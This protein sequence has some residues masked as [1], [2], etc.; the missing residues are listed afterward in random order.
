MIAAPPT[1]ESP[2]ETERMRVTGQAERVLT[3]DWYDDLVTELA[4]FLS[5]EVL[6][7]MSHPDIT[8]N[9]LKSYATQ[10]NVLY[11]EAPTVSA[12]G[13]DLTPILRPELWPLR[14]RGHLLTI[15]LRDSFMRLDYYEG[16]GV[17]YRVVSPAMILAAWADPKRPDVVV[18]L[19]ELRLRQFGDS[20][21]WTRDTWD[22]SNPAAPIFRIETQ[23]DSAWVDVTA[24]YHPDQPAGWYPY[25]R[26]GAPV[27][28]WIMYHPEITDCL[29]HWRERLELLDG[30]LKVGCLW[31][32]W[33]HGVRDCS[34][35]QRVAVDVDAPQASATDSLRPV[36]KIALDQSAILLLRS[37]NSRNGSVTTLAPAMD[38][39]ATADAILSYEAGMAQSAG[40]SAADVQQGGT[41]GMSGYAI[42][43]SRDGQ[44]RQWAAQR[45]AA[46]MGD[47]MLLATAAKLTNEYGSTSLPEEPEAY[48]ITYAEVGKTADEMLAELDEAM[49]LVDAGLIGPID[50]V[51]RVF[52]A[53]DQAAAIKHLHDIALQKQIV[54]TIS[55]PPP[56]TPGA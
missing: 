15:G 25:M 32:M 13:A 6:D 48:T 24:R 9:A 51:R 29:W 1:P 28:P 27:F 47:R 44:R 17:T 52:P 33:L 42:V 46:E 26:K 35:P 19:Q 49:K 54:A 36:D 39:K 5:P 10:S 55:G 31:T 22:V 30:T 12:G 8:R 14:Q 20:A 7:R 43:V 21:V 40:L 38:P 23:R 11:T 41:S 3:G 16:I 18:G 34:H 37:V 50:A 56:A 4:Q 2:D 45:P 53:M